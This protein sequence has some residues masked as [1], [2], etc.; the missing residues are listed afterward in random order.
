MPF[1]LA[2]ICFMLFDLS[3]A[4]AQ[5][6]I[7]RTAEGQNEIKPLEVGNSIPEE[8]WHLPLQVT[9]KNGTN[10][11]VSLDEHRGKLILLD[12]WSTWCPSCIR[13][14]PKLEKLQ[15]E[16]GEKIKIILVNS[17][18]TKDT[19]D[20]IKQTLKRYRNNY[21]YEIK[22][23]YILFDTLFQAMFPHRILPHFVWIDSQEKFRANSYSEAI[24]RVNIKAAI[25]GD[26]GNI[27][28]KDDFALNRA[29]SDLSRG[30]SANV[31]FSA[32]FTGYTEGAGMISEQL[33][34]KGEQTLYK[35]SNYPIAHF[36]QI[37]YADIFSGVYSNQWRFSETLTKEFTYSFMNRFD[38]ENLFCYEWRLDHSAT[39][40]E[41]RGVL[42]E[43]LEQ[44]FRVRPIRERSTG[45]VVVFQVNKQVEDIKSKGGIPQSRFEPTNGDLFIRNQ[46]L[47][48]LLNFF[49]RL[50]RCPID[51]E[52]DAT[53]NI[54]LVLPSAIY[55]YTEDQIAAYLSDL[56]IKMIETFREADYVVFE[57]LTDQ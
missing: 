30:Y 6:A 12:F 54:D 47:S 27:H 25:D 49:G 39:L 9:D 46:P 40:D 15:Q 37:A 36:Y 10:K 21:G 29:D 28:Q 57:S 53:Y 35:I 32:R 20:R 4:W 33:E 45:K 3:D 55:D 26:F 19:D 51:I 44:T 41:A 34:Q 8:L 24:N 52:G 16:F 2:L 43:T 7:S 17:M 11:T 1:V 42:R 48:S 5:S 18:Q 31:K 23:D 56:G 38:Y 22:L 13:G 14:F 50:L